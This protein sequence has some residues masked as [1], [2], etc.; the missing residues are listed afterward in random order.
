LFL[1]LQ[2]T[3]TKR[4]RLS[5][6]DESPCPVRLFWGELKTPVWVRI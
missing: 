3:T 1:I 2:V 6:G 4:Q 5:L